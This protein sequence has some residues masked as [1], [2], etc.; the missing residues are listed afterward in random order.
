MREELLYESFALKLA[1]PL[2][3][4]FESFVRNSIDSPAGGLDLVL[5]FFFFLFLMG[6]NK[7]M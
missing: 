7:L 1:E 4:F 3:G 5:V 6:Y 2:N